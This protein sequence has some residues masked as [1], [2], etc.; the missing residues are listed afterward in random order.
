M[1]VPA[2]CTI[3]GGNVEVASIPLSNGALV[4]AEF[5]N[6][7]FSGSFSGEASV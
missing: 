1:V 5:E 4:C 3:S 7:H 2:G 6:C